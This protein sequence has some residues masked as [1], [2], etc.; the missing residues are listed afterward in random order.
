MLAVLVVRRK[1][2]V[3]LESY[4]IAYTYIEY[5]MYLTQLVRAYII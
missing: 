3:Y 2:F 5:P 1:M 4:N